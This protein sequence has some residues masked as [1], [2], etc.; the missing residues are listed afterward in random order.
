MRCPMADNIRTS[1]LKT[2]RQARSKLISHRLEQVDRFIE[3]K[4]DEEAKVHKQAIVDTHDVVEA[5]DAAISDG[6][7]STRSTMIISLLSTLIAASALLV[8]GY[9]AY[10]TYQ[11]QKQSKQI[12]AAVSWCKDFSLPSFVAYQQD[13]RKLRLS[14]NSPFTLRDQDQ[15]PNTSALKSADDVKN[16]LASVKIDE[17]AR[18]KVTASLVGLLNYIETGATMVARGDMER[19]RFV[20][21]FKD[22]KVHYFQRFDGTYIGRLL[23]LQVTDAGKPLKK[24]ADLFDKSECLFKDGQKDATACLKKPGGK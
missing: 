3:A 18:E 4:T 22:F 23:S 7:P 16:Y 14:P 9:N 11:F 19:E 5:L 2:L 15:D 6:G 24:A 10:T 21:C 8:T 13:A 17:E 20:G 1:H 12:D